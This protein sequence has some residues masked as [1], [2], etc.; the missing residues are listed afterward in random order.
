MVC[1]RLEHGLACLLFSFARWLFRRIWRWRYF[2]AYIRLPY[3]Q[4]SR[5]SNNNPCWYAANLI[6][7]I[8]PLN[9]VIGK[10]ALLKITS[11][12]ALADLTSFAFQTLQSTQ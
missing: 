8:S 4:S 10:A 2:W 3:P 12:C 1:L 7:V 5:C 11:Q 9:L 6:N